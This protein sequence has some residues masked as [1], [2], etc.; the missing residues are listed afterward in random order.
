M[1]N[2]GSGENIEGLDQGFKI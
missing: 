2:P 1:K